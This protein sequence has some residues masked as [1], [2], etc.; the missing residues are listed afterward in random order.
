M[1]RVGLDAVVLMA[2]FLPLTAVDDG[3]FR[4]PRPLPA[5]RFSAREP[6]A[7]AE[8]VARAVRFFAFSQIPAIR[9]LS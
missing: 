3:G 6:V 2:E 5:L 7:H 8:A 9:R 4:S 1:A